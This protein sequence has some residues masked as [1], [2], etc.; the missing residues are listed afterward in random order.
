MDVAI[1]LEAAGADGQ[2]RA[3]AL[4]FGDGH[5]LVVADGAGGVAGGAAAA[6]AVVDALR[7][8]DPNAEH[9]WVQVL[10][11]LDRQ[12]SSSVAMGETTAV[13]ALV[14]E[15]EIRG[16]SVGDSGGW[17]L[18][19]SWL[20][21]LEGQKENRSSVAA[22]QSRSRLAHFPWARVYSW[23]LTGCSSTSLRSESTSSPA[24]HPWKMLRRASFKRRDYR[25]ALFK[26]TSPSSSRA[27][28]EL[29]SS[30]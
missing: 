8:L 22:R 23:D 18:L 1:R 5:L 4:P 19:G 15:G 25:A 24:A 10:T 9:D 20:D 21:L 27:S 6:Q 12:L 16:A 11:R 3:A 7:A 14:S 28:S 26:T 2:D 17:M 29:R 30:P 13:V